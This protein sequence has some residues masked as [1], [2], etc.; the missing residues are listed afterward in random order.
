[1][2][3]SKGNVIFIASQ[4]VYWTVP[5]SYLHCCQA[6]HE[7]I[8]ETVA[9]NILQKQIHPVFHKG[10]KIRIVE[11]VNPLTLSFGRVRCGPSHTQD[12]PHYEKSV[13]ISITLCV[14]NIDFN[15]SLDYIGVLK[16]I[17]AHF[18]FDIDS[19]H[20]VLREEVCMLNDHNIDIK[21]TSL[22]TTT[23]H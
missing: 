7:D 13:L 4:R 15:G 11:E 12:E 23:P 18:S 19:P 2:S 16:H 6:R 21:I 20:T 9:Q 14:D 5:T 10:A 3:K 17:S 8:L 22:N 1:M